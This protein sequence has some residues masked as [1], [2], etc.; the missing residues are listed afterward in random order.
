[1]MNTGPMP[2]ICGETGI[3]AEPFAADKLAAAM[4]QALKLDR[5]GLRKKLLERAAEFTWEKSM[6]AH[7]HIFSEM[8]N[9]GKSS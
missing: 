9:P 1:A 4:Q 8:A 2:E 5:N 7:A 3:Y 6:Q